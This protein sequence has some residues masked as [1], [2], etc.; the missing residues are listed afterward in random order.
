MTMLDRM[1]RHKNWL[2]WSLGLVVVTFIVF[3]IPD[4]LGTRQAAGP[5]NRDVV[6]EV[7]GQV[8]TAAEFRRAYFG[9]LQM[10]RSAYGGNVNEQLLRQL[11]IDRQILQQLVDERASLAEASRLGLTATDAE[12]AD[13]IMKIPA[14]QEN[15]QFV[16]EQRYKQILGLQ[17]PPLTHTEFEESLR[18]TIVLDKLRA[19]VSSWIGISNAEVDGEYRRRNEKVKLEVVAFPSDSFREGLTASD[20]EVAKYFEAN[21][22]EFRVGEKRKIRFLAIDVQKLRERVVVPPRDVERFYNQ[23]L[24]QYST[25]EQVR[26]SHIL[27]KTEGKDEAAVRAQAEQVLA[28]ARKGADFAELAKKYSEDEGSKANGG[29]LDFF[30]RG[31]MVPEFEQVA[32]SAEPGTISDLVKSQYGFHII[33]VVEKR[34]A[35]VRAL[36]DVRAQI[37]EQVKWERAQQQAS[38]MASRL[39]PEISSPSDLDKAAQQN[40]LVTQESGYF[41]RDEP[42]A[43]LGP[44]PEVAAEAFTLQDGQVSPALRTSQGYAFITVTG[45]QDSQLPKL[46]DVKDRVRDAVLRRKA[47]EAARAKAASVAAALKTATDF[48]AAAKAAGVESKTTEL[49]ARGSPL[50]DIGASPAVDAVAFGLPEG[51]VS[52]PIGTET[53]A[54]IVRVASREDVTAAQIEAGRSAL[55]EELLSERRNR[56]FSSYMTKAKARMAIA[57]NREVIQ[58]VI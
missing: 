40:G 33:K 24:E 45:R 37:A 34:E 38:D 57:I 54:V 6:A 39:G 48:A 12:V 29:D 53:G 55:R 18:R 30:G 14:F 17:N 31:R 32:F 8:I 25:P 51:A 3:Y 27:L 13:R 44:S 10:Y 26:A 42:I 19:A 56:F 15:G 5:G 49:I 41:L 9:Q 4:F 46:E 16:G 20:D 35:T 11:G 2:K 47:I 23:N 1:R 7:E 43:G 50:P 36:D 58:G 52:D 28:E 21:K 22:E